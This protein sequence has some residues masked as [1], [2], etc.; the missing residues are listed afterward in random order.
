[1]EP[2]AYKKPAS[3]SDIEVLK[4]NWRIGRDFLLA[5]IT[6]A[7]L[8]PGEVYDGSMGAFG[9]YAEVDIEI[10]EYP[11]ACIGCL[12]DYGELEF[13]GTGAKTVHFEVND[14]GGGVSHKGKDLI[15]ESPDEVI[16]NL[17]KDL[18]GYV[19]E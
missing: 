16:E 13:N 8:T 7:G 14:G 12:T 5:L 11:N 2:H 6:A 18:E 15:Y 10:V 9:T 4:E 3:D 17:K 1:M 19:G